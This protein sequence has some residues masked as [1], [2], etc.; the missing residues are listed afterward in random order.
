[1]GIQVL[2]V[3]DVVLSGGGSDVAFLV[4]VALDAAVDACHQH[5][6]ANVELSLLVQQWLLNVLLQYVR[7]ETAVAVLLFRFQPDLDLIQRRTHGNPPASVGHLSRFDNPDIL[8]IDSLVLHPLFIQHIVPIQKLPKL[9]ILQPSTNM[10]R[11]RNI[12]KRVLAIQLVVLAHPIKQRL[13][14]T[15]VV[16]ALEMVVRFLVCS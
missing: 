11:Q 15:N 12:L 3:P 13:L 1:M 10:I 8:Q 16:V 2:A 4:P 5:V 7:A 9:S 14:I 6:V